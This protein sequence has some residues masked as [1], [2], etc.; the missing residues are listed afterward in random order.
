[1]QA[2]RL[3]APDFHRTYTA[4]VRSRPRGIFTAAV[5]GIPV[6]RHSSKAA[7]HVGE[8]AG[9]AP[10]Q[11]A[12]HFPPRSFLTSPPVAARVI[13]MIARVTEVERS[14]WWDYWCGST[15]L[16]GKSAKWAVGT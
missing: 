16:W 5:S 2:L 13:A 7:P 6:S 15:A 11:G 9:H 14:G 8:S 12:G 10:R 1:M 4:V 3:C